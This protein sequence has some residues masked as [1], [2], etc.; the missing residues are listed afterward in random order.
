MRAKSARVQALKSKISSDLHG[1]DDDEPDEQSEF[2]KEKEDD[3]QSDDE[4]LRAAK[5]KPKP[6]QRKKKET[7]SM[8]EA[9][10]APSST[11][12]KTSFST[13][14]EGE[15]GQ[16]GKAKRNQKSSTHVQSAKPTELEI[17][18]LFAILC[19]VHGSGETIG[20]GEV[21]D[22][23]V[24]LGLNIEEATLDAMM[25]FAQ[26]LATGDQYPGP[27]TSKGSNQ[28]KARISFETFRSICSHIYSLSIRPCGPCI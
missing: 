17:K 18:E 20:R 22:M 27:S 16:K 9:A 1:L 15:P 25:G 26:D 23:I 3:T 12:R 19:G 28:S 10:V 8:Q 2:E 21:E 7:S 4:E 5:P 11:K 24:K 14:E 13:G 6:R